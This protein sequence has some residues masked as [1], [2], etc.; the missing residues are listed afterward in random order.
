MAQVGFTNLRAY[1]ERAK[2]SRMRLGSF[3]GVDSATIY[4][5]ECKGNL[6]RLPTARKLVRA[7]S[8]TLGEPLSLE[9]VF[10]KTFDKEEAS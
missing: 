1:R 7:L 9:Q 6:P 10:T 3:A 2:L 5:I 8:E 4:G